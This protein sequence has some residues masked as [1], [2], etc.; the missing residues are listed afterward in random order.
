MCTGESCADVVKYT[1]AFWRGT[2]LLV[3]QSVCPGRGL[4]SHSTQTPK[5]HA[6]ITCMSHTAHIGGRRTRIISIL[7]RGLRRTT[8][9]GALGKLVPLL[10]T[11]SSHHT[12][13]CLLRGRSRPLRASTL[14]GSPVCSSALCFANEVKLNLRAASVD[15]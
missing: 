13:H 1:K 14:W 10:Y 5:Y 4:R 11:V 6:N 7:H 2:F 9:R 8:S 3:L 12:L 15:F